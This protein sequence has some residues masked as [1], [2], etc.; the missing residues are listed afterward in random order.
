[1]LAVVAPTG[2]YN[3]TVLIN[4]GL[5]AGPSNRSLADRFLG[6]AEVYS[7]KEREAEVSVNFVACHDGFT[8][9]DTV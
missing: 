4:P 2:Q 3:P 5:T 7:H 1:M 6:S 8:L 9:N